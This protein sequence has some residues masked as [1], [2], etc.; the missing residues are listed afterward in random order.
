M[1]WGNGVEEKFDEEGYLAIPPCLW[2]PDTEGLV[3]PVYLPM[4]ANLTSIKKN[5]NT[6]CHY[7]EMASW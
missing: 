3:K 5:N 1:T 6:N 7:G 4:N 2:G